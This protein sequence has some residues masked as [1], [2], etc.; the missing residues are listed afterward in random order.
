MSSRISIGRSRKRNGPGG[1]SCTVPGHVSHCSDLEVTR[2]ELTVRTFC[3][4]LPFF[5]FLPLFDPF[6]IIDD[7]DDA[8]KARRRERELE[9]QDGGDGECA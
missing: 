3:T 4:T 1:F 6:P 8:Q 9:V 2:D 7:V 5:P